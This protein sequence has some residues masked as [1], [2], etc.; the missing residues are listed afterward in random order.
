MKCIT[1]YYEN[2]DQEFE[3]Q[4][5]NQKILPTNQEFNYKYIIDNY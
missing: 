4:T 1:S 5:D 3:K 2:I